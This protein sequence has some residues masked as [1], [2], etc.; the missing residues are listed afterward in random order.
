MLQRSNFIVVF[1]QKMDPQASFVN[2]SS[3]TWAYIPENF[4]LASW[5]NVR[6][7]DGQTQY[8]AHPRTHLSSTG[9]ICMWV[10]DGVIL[11]YFLAVFLGVHRCNIV[12]GVPL[13]PDA[14]AATESCYCKKHKQLF[15]RMT[16]ATPETKTHWTSCMLM[17]KCISSVSPFLFHH[18]QC[19]VPSSEKLWCYG[20]SCVCGPGG[21]D[22]VDQFRGL[23]DNHLHLATTK[24]NTGFMGK[25]ALPSLVGVSVLLP[26]CLA[27]FHV[28]IDVISSL[29]QWCFIALI[30]VLIKAHRCHIIIN[31]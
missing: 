30:W 27:V 11:D 16:T 29:Q 8:V 23:C 7:W 31:D 24:Q 19:T 12:V 14:E 22:L 3:K 20:H 25:Q 6:S 15:I 21:Q 13:W 17:L 2:G 5:V 1:W 28:I 26:V 9:S 18:L 4:I 10:R